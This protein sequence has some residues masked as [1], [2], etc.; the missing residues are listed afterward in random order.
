MDLVP[1]YFCV[2]VDHFSHGGGK[3][4]FCLTSVKHTHKHAHTLYTT[5]A[6]HGTKPS[7]TQS[8]AGSNRVFTTD[9]DLLHSLRSFS[10]SR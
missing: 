3:K 4:Q 2:C 6:L 10:S 8:W 9:I 5:R 7:A 1:L